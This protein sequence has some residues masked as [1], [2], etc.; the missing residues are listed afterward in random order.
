[1]LVVQSK[2][3]SFPSVF[4]FMFITVRLLN[5]FQEPLLY[6]VPG[7]WLEK[8]RIGS[9]VHVPLRANIVAALVTEIFD[10]KPDGIQFTIK[11]AVRIETMPQDTQYA[12][13]IDQLAHY[14]LLDPTLLVGRLRQF[15]HQKIQ[16]PALISPNYQPNTNVTLSD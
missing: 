4:I 9:I 10:Q 6:Q 8:P 14:H 13:F 2:L 12:L 16:A 1:M 11:P 5:Q 3:P 7:D 15:V